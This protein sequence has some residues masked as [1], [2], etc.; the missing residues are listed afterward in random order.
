MKTLESVHKDCENYKHLEYK[1]RSC[2]GGKI[3]K[4]IV[5]MILCK[6]VRVSCLNCKGCINYRRKDE[7]F[8]T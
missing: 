3:I 5:E 4:D 7:H 2:C 8:N 6:G 1:E